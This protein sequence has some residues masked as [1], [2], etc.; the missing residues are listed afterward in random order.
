MRI[1]KS[2][3]EFHFFHFPG[4]HVVHRSVNESKVVGRV[5]VSG[6]SGRSLKVEAGPS[7]SQKCFHW[8]LRCYQG[9]T[10]D[11]S[12]SEPQHFVFRSD[13]IESKTCFMRGQMR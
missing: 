5:G 8:C 6:P 4:L 9:N 10:P 11:V 1:V 12:R 3:R 2:E 13:L 7:V